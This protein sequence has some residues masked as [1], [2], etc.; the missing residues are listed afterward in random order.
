MYAR[1]EI[2][3]LTDKVLTMGAAA[4]TDG[5]EVS[6]EGGERAGTRW[7]NSTISTNLVQYDQQ[8]T[9]NARVGQKQGT[10]TTREFDDDALKA[11]VEEA[12][13]AAKKARDNPNLPPLV[14]GP[15]TYIPVDAA[16]PE[17]V[18]F[19]PGERAKW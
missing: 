19:G 16:R 5:T 1:D 8:L 11:A 17:T 7:A 13:E 12:V 14:K 6:F 9:I 3:N 2:K 18:E 15:Q 10:A 4:K